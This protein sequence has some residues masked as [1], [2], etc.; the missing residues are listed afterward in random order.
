MN[1]EQFEKA[2][3][4]LVAKAFEEDDFKAKLL[5][6]PKKTFKENGIEMPEKMKVNIVEN[7]YDLVNFV[8]PMDISELDKDDLQQLSG[9]LK[10]KDCTLPRQ[11]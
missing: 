9:G 5:A 7:K 4:K 8:L 2:Y 1:K 6:D 3:G 11:F 10:T